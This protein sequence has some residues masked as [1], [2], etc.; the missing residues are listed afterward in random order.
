LPVRIARISTVAK[1][2]AL[3]THFP[4]WEYRR[5]HAIFRTRTSGW[6]TFFK[7]NDENHQTSGRLVGL[8]GHIARAVFDLGGQVTGVIPDFL[9]EREVAF[10]DLPDLRIVR[11]MHEH[12]ALVAELSDGFIICL[13]NVRALSATEHWQVD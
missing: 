9:V 3:L 13:L 10:T 1:L 11:S 5:Q 2:R 8:M 7:T 6:G 12:K 4:F